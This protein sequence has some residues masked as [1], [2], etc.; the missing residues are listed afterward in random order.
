[1]HDDRLAAGAGGSTPTTAGAHLLVVDD[2]ATNR[3]LLGRRLTQHGYL[4]RTA[5]HTREALD[6]LRSQPC[7]AVLLDVMMPG[8]SGLALLAAIRA[9]VHLRQ[10]PVIMVTARSDRR[11][12]IEALELGADDYVT[13]PIDFGVTL[14]RVQARLARASAE[15]TALAVQRRDDLEHAQKLSV[16]GRL[17]TGV[18]HDLNNLLMAIR[19]YGE[20]LRDDLAPGDPRR[21]HADQVLK[22]A[23]SAAG[24]TRRLLAAGRRA[25]A[26]AP[27]LL[28]LGA[29]TTAMLQ[30]LGGVLGDHI[31]VVADVDEGLWP[32]E[33][34][35][36]EFE[37][38]LLNL[39]VNAADAMAGGGTLHVT[40]ANAS[41]DAGRPD[42][43][44]VALTV[45]DTGCGMSPE[46][47]A[48]I[49]EPFF[50]TKTATDGT[51]LGLAMVRAIADGAGG[52]VT[53]TTAPGRGSTFRMFVPRAGQGPARP[54][55]SRR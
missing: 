21:H 32:V 44:G 27:M 42:Q 43:E 29:V 10:L 14:A 22:A 7:D 25:P 47:A 23:G 48:R 26:Q 15:R 17:T 55:D 18:A 1:V 2:D 16:V 19:G 37:Q 49:F 3:D 28:D 31:H 8:E 4:V 41:A 5:A 30:L 38:V 24:L 54:A 35:A 9:D 46:T 52:T 50:T 34:D 45:A 12:V 33:G 40:V 13:K 6:L 39:V 11:D 20:F 53:V 51:G 36:G